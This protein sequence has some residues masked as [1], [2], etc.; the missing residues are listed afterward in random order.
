MYQVSTKSENQLDYFHKEN[1]YFKNLFDLQSKLPIPGFVVALMF[2]RPI[3]NISNR[4]VDWF[5]FRLSKTSWMI[6]N[7]S[8]ANM[9]NELT[10]N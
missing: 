3:A 4:N 7:V 2:T 10:E 6:K 9:K 5:I 8:L 1:Y